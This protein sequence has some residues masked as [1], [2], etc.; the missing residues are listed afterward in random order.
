MMM[1][2]HSNAKRLPF[3]IGAG[4]MLLAGGILVALS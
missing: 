3:L 1:A 2:F 4:L